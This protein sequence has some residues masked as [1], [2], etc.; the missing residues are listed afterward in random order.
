MKIT[1]IIITLGLISFLLT[2]AIRYL[3]LKHKL[4]D[5]PNE[6]SS[7]VIPTPTG[8]GLAIVITWYIG[9][10]LL[11]ILRLIESSLYFALLTGII[12]MIISLIDDFVSLK[13][14]IRL[15][16]HFI[17][18]IIAFYFLG[19]LRA[20]IIPGL[21]MQYFIILYPIVILGMV[22]FV[23]L[24]NFMDGLDGFASTE[25]VILA[26]VMFI[27]SG[28][29]INLIL[30]ISIAGFLYWNWPRAKIFMGDVGSI[31]LGFILV[32]LGIYFH[33]TFQFSIL[34]WIMLSSPFW[35]DATYTLF[36]RWRNRERLSQ[37][38][39]KHA[40]QRIAQ[41]GFS[42]Q[43]VNFYLIG[44]NSIVVIIILLY[45]EFDFLKIALFI[46]SLL[47]FYFITRLI[48][49]KVPFN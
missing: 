36:R 26:L 28:N 23:N 29:I 25:A 11:F 27:F 5:V 9:I 24:F 33:N 38:H 32:I 31:Q 45:R 20:F 39:K 7:H 1:G 34:N 3:A 48:D 15:I 18:V 21:S 30:I 8:G 2:Y 41:A 46:I 40:Y 17:T 22:W 49:K 19:G 14:F 47:F 12:L 42:H 44:I 35:F 6:R 10:T 13:P 43:K 4:L 16:F 37:A